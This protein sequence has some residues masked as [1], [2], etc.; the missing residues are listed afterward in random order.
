MSKGFCLC[1]LMHLH[2]LRNLWSPELRNRRSVDVYLP[3]SYSMSRQRYPVVYMQDGQNLSDPAQAF[4]GTW[5]LP[6]TGARLAAEGLDAIVVGIHNIGTGRAAEY[7]PF[8]DSRHGGGY[9]PR[10]VQFIA[11]T[12]K[13]RIDRRFRSEPGRAST[14]IGGSSMGGLIALYAFIRHARLFGGAL[15]MSPALWFGDRGVFPFIERSL[16]AP[17]GRL[18]LDVGTAEGVE[19]LRDARRLQ[20]LLAAKGYGPSRL[21]YVEAE[22]APHA[23]SA[24]GARLPDALRFLLR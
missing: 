11:R 22:G 24:W 18:Y 13:P 19:A 14:I 15:V 17:H 12:L 2:T 20:R 4:A 8:R 23:E 1:S 16:T 6:R 21:R 5:E 3:P 10:Y 7:S 9:G